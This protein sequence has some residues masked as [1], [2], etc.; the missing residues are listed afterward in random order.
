[1]LLP[2]IEFCVRYP[3]VG[4]N[5]IV[6]SLLSA[7]GQLFIFYALLVFDSLVCTTI[8]TVRKFMTIVISVVFHHNALSGWQWLS[9]LMVFGAV[10]YDAG[11]LSS[12]SEVL[13]DNWGVTPQALCCAVEDKRR[14]SKKD[15]EDLVF[16]MQEVETA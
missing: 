3:T 4:W 9:V 16:C 7:L 14:K 6:F 15:E 5:L 11:L 2:Q 10:A 13:E 12:A 8:T 1:V